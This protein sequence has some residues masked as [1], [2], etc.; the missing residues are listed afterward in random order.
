MIHAL[1]LDNAFVLYNERNYWHT[2]AFLFSKNFNLDNL[3]KEQIQLIDQ[4]SDLM[5]NPDININKLQVLYDEN[6][7]IHEH[8]RSIMDYYVKIEYE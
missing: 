8:S 6:P 3:E 4:I 5:I 2:P 7:F 1:L